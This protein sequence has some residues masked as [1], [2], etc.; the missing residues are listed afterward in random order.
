MVRPHAIE[1]LFLM[2]DFFSYICGSR[3]K[4]C[5][6]TNDD[7][8]RLQEEASIRVARYEADQ[9]AEE[10]EMRAAVAAVRAAAEA[11]EAERAL[12]EERAQ[13]EQR[14]YER[15]ER[16]RLENI[17]HYYGYL[18]EVLGRVRLMQRTAIEKRHDCE[19]DEIDRMRDDLDS[20]EKA[21]DM[22]REVDKEREEIISKTNNTI[23]ALQRRHATT[24]METITR[25][26]RDQDDFF[27]MSAECTDEATNLANAE[28]LEWLMS[29][30]NL[31]R[32]T[33]KAQ[34][35]HE[36]Q[37]YKTRCEGSLKDFDVKT[38]I[39]QMRLGEAEFI[40][41]REKA[42]RSILHADSKWFDLIF[43]VRYSMLMDDQKRMERSGADAPTGPKRDTVVFPGSFPCSPRNE[44]FQ[45]GGSGKGSL[46]P[47]AESII[48]RRVSKQKS[49]T[50]RSTIFPTDQMRP[51]PTAPKTRD[52]EPSISTSQRPTPSISLQTNMESST[53]NSTQSYPARTSSHSAGPSTTTPADWNLP[54]SSPA[55]RTRERSVSAVTAVV[56]QIASPIVSPAAPKREAPQIPSHS[57][58]RRDKNT[59]P[60]LPWERYGNDDV[61]QLGGRSVVKDGKGR[62]KG[63]SKGPGFIFG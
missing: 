35:V 26:R 42:M 52:R 5:R 44:D 41:Q 25:H 7:L 6:C 31:E 40:S 20:A 4:T 12:E 50:P 28:K 32:S 13:E 30:H 22:Q 51:P 8:L 37:K 54:I 53:L 63:G 43:D 58:W 33:L 15:Q 39:L 16:V 14:E 45:D 27:D 55:P 10:E 3:W 34:Q 17:A 21:A 57:A 1:L 23:K 29:A 61:I 19:W 2:I 59:R 46:T 18:R 9:R 49:L 56:P 38:K 24:M 36:I 48:A 47:R 60:P 62:S 11:L